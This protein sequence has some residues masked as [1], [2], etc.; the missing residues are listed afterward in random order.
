MLKEKGT[1]ILLFLLTILFLLTAENLFIS[2]TLASEPASVD[3]QKQPSRL[4]GSES[5]PVYND[6]HNSKPET[7]PTVRPETYNERY[8][9]KSSQYLPDSSHS[10][11]ETSYKRYSLFRYGEHYILCEPYIVKRGD[12]VYK[13]FRSKGELSKKDFGLFIRIF[14]AINPD[15]K[16]TNTIKTG[17]CITIPLKKSDK[18]DFKESQPGVVD[19]PIITLSQIPNKFKKETE[20]SKETESN[21]ETPSSFIPIQKESSDTTAAE[22]KSYATTS[23]TSSEQKTYATASKISSDKGF[24]SVKTYGGLPSEIPVTQLKQFAMLNNGQL[25]T[26]GKYYFP[27]EKGDDLVVDVELNPLV[28]FK[29]GSKILFVH[30]KNAFNEFADT[31]R[32]FW[33]NL[34]IVEFGELSSSLSVQPSEDSYPGRRS[35]G[36]PPLN[37]PQVSMKSNIQP[38][39]SIMEPQD[40]IYVP[41]SLAVPRDHK[42]AVKLLLEITGYKYRPEKDISVSVGN[43]TIQVS[44][45]FISR[46]NRPDILVIFGDIYGSA[47]EALKKMELGDI[48][49]ISPLLTPM[50]VTRKLLSAIRAS[51]TENPAFVNPANNKTISLNGIY[52]NIRYKE[53]FITEKPMLLKD[54][55]RYLT[56]K[57]I[58]IVRVDQPL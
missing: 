4:Y 30:K 57:K 50:D 51:T 23:K 55:F 33:K 8:Q 9:K 16:D 45:G 31:I 12:W 40:E 52:A 41:I 54:A 34:K 6:L 14:K 36:S 56:E 20:S 26:R 17:Q 24:Y 44:P 42:V 27:R 1:A 15:I 48:V 19:L 2:N 38:V 32:V 35:P 13:I 10:I 29:D 58:A 18:N 39:P 53:F 43:I 22:Q 37:R 47:L 49:I 25:V 5:K 46:D 3:N 28:S 21:P 11:L 7:L